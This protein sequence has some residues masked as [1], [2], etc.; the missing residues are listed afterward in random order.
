MNIEKIRW[1]NR[2][3]RTQ[4][5]GARHGVEWPRVRALR[6]HAVSSEVTTVSAR[7]RSRSAA[8]LSREV[9][10]GGDSKHEQLHRHVIGLIV[11]N[12]DGNGGSCAQHDA[13]DA[14]HDVNHGGRIGERRASR[15]RG[16]SRSRPS[17]AERRG[18]RWRC[19]SRCGESA[20]R[21]V[22][23]HECLEDAMAKWKLAK[24][25]GRSRHG[26]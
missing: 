21:C 13:G 19:R 26:V 6:S 4:R 5:F 11:T 25:A 7:A 8:A 18:D 12:F 24:P 2:H 17:V 3:R 20:P 23:R 22:D 10:D 16:R 15:L 9:R 1:G 14:G